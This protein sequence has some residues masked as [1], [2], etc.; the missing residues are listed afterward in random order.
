MNIISADISLIDGK[1]R[2]AFLKLFENDPDLYQI[3]ERLIDDLGYTFELGSLIKLREPFDKLFK[4]R[5]K[6]AL[7][8]RNYAQQLKL[9]KSEK[10]QLSLEDV[11]VSVPPELTIK[12]I[13]KYLELF[14]K[15][16]FE[17]HSIGDIIFS[18]DA[19][20][21][22]GLLSLLMKK[23]DVVLMNPP[24]GDVTPKA[25]AYLKEHYPKTHNDV[26]SAFIEQAVDLTEEGGY[27]GMLTNLTFM[28]LSS[29]RWLRENLLKEKAPPKLIL[30]FGLGILD[31]ASVYTAGTILRKGERKPGEETLFLRL[32]EPSTE[33]KEKLFCE[34]L[35][36]IL[37]EKPHSELFKASL[38]DLAQVPGT[39]SHTHLTLPTK[40]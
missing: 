28:Y 36:H 26:Y 37:K 4:V 12:H 35:S 39:V 16:A 1:R 17:R 6:K 13:E 34:I 15:Q 20:R 7:E 25:K 22:L 11:K 18:I 2:E 10:I 23:Y 21:S 24:Y 33:E 29:H 14:E 19:A 40:A 31:G 5:K 8:L 30:E 27:I 32:T 3:A 38:E 9:F